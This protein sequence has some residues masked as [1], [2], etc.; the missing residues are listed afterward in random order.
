MA[1]VFTQLTFMYTCKQDTDFYYTFHWVL[2]V[3]NYS[4]H[5][6]CRKHSVDL[7]RLHTQLYT[8]TITKAIPVVFVAVKLVML[9]MSGL[10]ALSYTVVVAEKYRILFKVFFQYFAIRV[11]I[12]RMTFAFLISDH[13]YYLYFAFDC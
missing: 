5:Q 8:V 4:T 1:Y 11:A 7:L 12:F 10:S 9:T 3:V 13:I 6:T 2:L